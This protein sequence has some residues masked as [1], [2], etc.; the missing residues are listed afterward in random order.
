LYTEEEQNVRRNFYEICKI[1]K[2]KTALGYVRGIGNRDYDE[3]DSRKSKRG[4]HN[5]R[6][7]GNS[8]IPRKV[9]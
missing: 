4:V 5:Q 2:E 9:G 6:R 3:R 7:I 8:E 1:R